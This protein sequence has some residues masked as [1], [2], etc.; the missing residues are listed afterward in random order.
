MLRYRREV[1]LSFAPKTDLAKLYCKHLA[2]LRQRRQDVLTV[3]PD[4]RDIL[5][6]L[7]KKR[8]RRERELAEVLAGRAPDPDGS[9]DD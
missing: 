8:E 9:D 4:R 6:A 1:G 5:K 3:A 7:D 2:I